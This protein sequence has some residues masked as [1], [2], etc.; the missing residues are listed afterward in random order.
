MW[1]ETCNADCFFKWNMQFSLLARRNHSRAP[2]GV[3]H[4]RRLHRNDVSAVWL[5]KNLSTPF[6]YLILKI[7]QLFKLLNNWHLWVGGFSYFEFFGAAAEYPN[8]VQRR[9]KGKGGTIAR[10]CS[11]VSRYNL[12]QSLRNPET[13][14]FLVYVP[15]KVLASH[16]WTRRK[17]TS[18]IKSGN[19]WRTRREPNRL[20]W[21]TV[22][23]VCNAYMNGE[24]NSQIRRDIGIR[25]CVVFSA[26]WCYLCVGW[27]WRLL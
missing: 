2:I 8:W 22:R 16:P 3:F 17:R 4:K 26:D 12:A 15:L 1:R 9:A 11:A 19:N 18:E 27:C 5:Q 23:I 20:H 10:N 6:F 13:V 25:I 24:E 21:N 14:F 7:I